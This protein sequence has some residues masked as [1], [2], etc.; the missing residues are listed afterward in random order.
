M[1]TI[2]IKTSYFYKL[3]GKEMSKRRITLGKTEFE[4]LCFNYGLEA[5]DD[6]DDA[7]CMK[8]EVPANRYDLLSVEGLA[9]NLGRYLG[10]LPEFKFTPRPAS[11]LL[12]MHVKPSVGI[13]LN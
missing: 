7:E 11:E 13:Y 10:T 2:K 12:T 3:L 8:V 6:K 9:L 5:E 4:E 1:P